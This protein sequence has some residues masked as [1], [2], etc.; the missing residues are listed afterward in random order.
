MPQLTHED[1]ERA[2]KVIELLDAGDAASV[3]QAVETVMKGLHV[4]N[5]NDIQAAIK[6]LSGAVPLVRKEMAAQAEVLDEVAAE[7]AAKR[8]AEAEEA[9]AER[10]DELI[11]EEDR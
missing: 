10:R 3:P 8:V 7:D 6:R 2:R 11:P 1:R 9:A 5:E 4:F